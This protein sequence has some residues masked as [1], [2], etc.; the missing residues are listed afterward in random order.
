M[1]DQDQK[2]PLGMVLQSAGLIS[3]QQLAKALKIQAEYTQ[4]KLGEILILQE[5]I[6]PQTIDFFVYQWQEIKAEG[7]QLPLGQYLQDA[8]LLNSEQVKFILAEQQKQQRLFGEIAVEQGW[9][10]QKTVD[11]FVNSLAVKVPHLVSFNI[12]EKYNQKFLNLEKKYTNHEAIL[13]RIL[14][15]TGG[16]YNLSKCISQEFATAHFNIPTGREINVVD[17]FI[18]GSLIQQWQTIEVGKYLRYVKYR[19]LNNKRQ[20]SIFLLEEYR[21]ILL[22]GS[23]QYDQS[24]IQNELL[25]LGLIVEQDNQL[26]PSN[27]IYQQI[28][29][30]DWIAT[31][32]AKLQLNNKVKPAIYQST[33]D[34]ELSPSINNSQNESNSPPQVKS[35]SSRISTPQNQTNNVL[36]NTNTS[37]TEDNLAVTPDLLNQ[38]NTR[39]TNNKA[40]V[41]NDQRNDETNPKALEPIT[42]L[43]SLITLFGIILFIPLVLIINNYYSPVQ[44]N[45]QSGY[46]PLEDK[47]KLQQF[48]RDLNLI[49][50]KTSLSLMSQLEKN[51]LELIAKFPDE[52]DAFP[53]NCEVVLNKLRVLAAP[54]LGR[55]N[56]VIEAIKN[57]CKVPTDSESLTE[58]KIWLDNWYDSP[59]WGQRTKAY[60]ALTPEC[61]ANDR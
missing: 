26:R 47:Q 5:A 33:K 28:F 9:I 58:A 48:C 41:D 52:P 44:S 3:S 49:D 35:E 61:A 38:N 46:D 60:L 45:S 24:N 16:N 37:L 40:L 14:A 30:Q 34:E 20:N 21:E 51:K 19:L 25:V 17:K 12:L 13:T 36:K 31:Q 42:K 7:Q 18:E 43:G 11:F 6:Q 23:K 56:R 10:K 53:R 8:H 2:K 4:M 15:W 54:Q 59:G 32:I 39:N 55:E 50:P 29:H 57:L 1:L 22:A 27:L